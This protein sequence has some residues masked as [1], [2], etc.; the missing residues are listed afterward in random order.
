MSRIE[1]HHTLFYRRAWDAMGGTAK[2]RNDPSLIAP[3][4]A[5]AHVELHRKVPFVPPLSDHIARRAVHEYADRPVHDRH[6]LN[7]EELQRSIYKATKHEKVTRLE[8]DVSMLA[9][10]ALGM[11]LPYLRETSREAMIKQAEFE[12]QQL[13]ISIDRARGE[14][15]AQED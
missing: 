11:Q 13:A 8:H 9:I 1:R 7:V 14:F 10:E 6:D 4:D 5:D 15:Y 2:L 12:A 3:L